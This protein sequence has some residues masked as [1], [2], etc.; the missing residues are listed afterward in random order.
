MADP[1]SISASVA[2]LVGLAISLTQVSYQY[3]TSVKGSSKAWSSYMQ[4]LSA[5]TSVLLRLQAARDVQ[6]RESIPTVREPEV[7]KTETDRCIHEL[8]QLKT[9]LDDKLAKRGIVGK[10]G[11]LVWPFSEAETQ[12]KVEMLHRYNSI[13]SSALLA[14][15]LY[16][17]SLFNVVFLGPISCLMAAQHR[18]DSKLS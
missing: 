2:G 9:K 13:F 8:Q 11:A 12:K 1:L 4:E 6:D 5:L 15:N 3:A 17:S 14:D 16:V 18:F 10:L 7:S